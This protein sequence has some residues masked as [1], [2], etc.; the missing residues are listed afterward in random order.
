MYNVAEGVRGM[1][2]GVGLRRIII[3]SATDCAFIWITEKNCKN[4]REVMTHGNMVDYAIILPE[5]LVNSFCKTHS[6][7]SPSGRRDGIQGKSKR[8]VNSFLHLL[9]VFKFKER[10][11]GRRGRVNKTWRTER[12]RESTIDYSLTCESGLVSFSA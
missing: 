6:R 2:V 3:Y 11:K 4:Q 10:Q 8:G 7:H 9:R 1:G 12:F 5:Q